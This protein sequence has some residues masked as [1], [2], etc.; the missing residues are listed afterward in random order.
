M[1]IP[2]KGSRSLNV[3]G[4]KFRYSVRV[5]DH[6]THISDHYDENQKDLLLTV[7]EDKKN[8]GRVCQAVVSE[9]VTPKL[10]CDAI[11]LFKEAGWNPSERGG[12]FYYKPQ[13]RAYGAMPPGPKKVIG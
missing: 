3:N 6:L 4:E 12:P 9:P 7:Q 5:S 10:V 13:K 2:R 11:E 8:P 1:G